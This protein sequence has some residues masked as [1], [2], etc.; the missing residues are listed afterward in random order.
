MRNPFPSLAA[1]CAA[2][3]LG[4]FAVNVHAAA[5]AEFL[6]DDGLLMSLSQHEPDKEGNML[7][8]GVMWEKSTTPDTPLKPK[9]ITVKIDPHTCAMGYGIMYRYNTLDLKEKMFVI[10]F[11]MYPVGTPQGMRGNDDMTNSSIAH[12][13]CRK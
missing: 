11:T 2:A 1:V 7:A 9:Y 3:L 6:F 4:G 12:F 13:V 5:Y 10:R 8:T